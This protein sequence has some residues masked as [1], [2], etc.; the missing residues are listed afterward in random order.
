M[1][2]LEMLM[3]AQGGGLV[4]QLAGRFGLDE[5]QAGAALQA[6][7]PALTGGLQNNMTQEGGLDGL[8]GALTGGNHQEYLDNPELLGEQSTV[9]DGNSILGHILGSKE[10]SRQVAGQAAAETG[11]SS[12]LL[13]QMLPVVATL[14]MGALSKHASQQGLGAGDQQSSSGDLL[15]MLGGFLGGGSNASL[16]GDVL[17]MVGKFLQR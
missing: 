6:L 9:E 13:K 4:S 5:S 11:L 7:L 8:V 1:N 12:D 14:A 16:A 2:L 15:G 3:N 17:G 10:V